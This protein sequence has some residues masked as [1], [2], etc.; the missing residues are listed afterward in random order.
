[1]FKCLSKKRGRLLIFIILGTIALAAVCEYRIMKSNK[2]LSRISIQGRDMSAKTIEETENLLVPIFQEA[3]SRQITIKHGERKWAFLAEEMGLQ[4]ALE[5]TVRE[6]WSVG[7]RGYFWQRWAERVT[8]WRHSKQVPLLFHQDDDELKKV[9]LQIARTIDIEPQNAVINITAENK[10]QVE[11]G[12]EG[13]KVDVNETFAALAE[14]LKSPEQSTVELKVALIKPEITTG[15]VEE[16]KITGVI[17]SFS[18]NFD[19]GKEGRSSNIKIAAKELDRVLVMGREVFSFNEVVG[20]RT[21][22]AGYQESLVIENNEFTPGLGGGVCQVSTTLYNAVLK[23]N[24]SI[25]ERIPHSLPVTYTPPGMDATVAYDWADLKFLNDLSTPVLLHTE[26][27][28][29]NIN[30]IIFGPAEKVPQVN[31]FS[32]VVKET[33]PEED[34]IEDPSVPPGTQVVEKQ[35]HKGME[36]EV[37]REVMEENQVVFR[38]VISRDIYKAVKSV[39]RVAPKS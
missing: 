11:P 25:I 17:A 2:I 10:I 18:T 30:I 35:G 37:I 5:D 39:V 19:P 8:A 13:Q 1:M 24:F 34:I 31:V 36:V 38:E 26:Y 7:R 28:P 15:D 16:W 32:R 14:T 9:I 27:K 20:P 22:E 4:S 3:I 6:A 29:G 12:I 33:E 23:A 21:K